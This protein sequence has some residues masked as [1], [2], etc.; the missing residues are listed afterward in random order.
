MRPVNRR[1]R[2]PGVGYKHFDLIPHAHGTVAAT[3]VSAWV[4]GVPM[5]SAVGV[6][7]VVHLLLD[8]QEYTSDVVL[9]YR[10]V[11]GTCEVIGDLSGGLVG[12]ALC[13]QHPKSLLDDA[14]GP[15]SRTN[16][17]RRDTV[18]RRAG[19]LAYSTARV[20]RMTVTLIWPG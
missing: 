16:G 10:K 8:I 5:L 6:A 3:V 13:V 19:H 4:L 7:T 14:L 15:L 12:T 1:W 20:S 18:R 17:A 9:S 2:A 11:R